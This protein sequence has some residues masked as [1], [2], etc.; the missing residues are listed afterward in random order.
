MEE[1]PGT[2]LYEIWEGLPL[3]QKVAIM[4]DLVRIQEKML[5]APLNRYISL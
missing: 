5:L 3:E 2:G 4:E 1:A